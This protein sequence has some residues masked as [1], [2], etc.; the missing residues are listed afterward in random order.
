VIITT[1][2]NFQDNEECPDKRTSRTLCCASLKKS[3]L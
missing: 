3:W 2:L 1:T